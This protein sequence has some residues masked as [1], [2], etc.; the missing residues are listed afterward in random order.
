LFVVLNVLGAS[1]A[2]YGA[3]SIDSSRLHSGDD[4]PGGG[5][6]MLIFVSLPVIACVLADLIALAMAVAATLKRPRLA[7]ATRFVAIMLPW[8]IA[9]TLGPLSPR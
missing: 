3:W 1:V 9:F 8:L 7:P 6:A 4:G 5:L 2:S